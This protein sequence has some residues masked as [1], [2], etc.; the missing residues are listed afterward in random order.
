[1]TD[2]LRITILADGT[3]RTETDAISSANHQSAEDFLKGVTLATGG[4]AQR[5]R[6]QHGHVHAH[7]H[8]TAHVHTDGHSHS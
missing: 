2:T 3:I 7:N 5:T 8:E 4:E 6:R 1:M